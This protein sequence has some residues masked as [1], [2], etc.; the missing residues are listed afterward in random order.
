MG[1]LAG[2]TTH[3]FPTLL[4]GVAI[5]VL[6]S[7]VLRVQRSFRGYDALDPQR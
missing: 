2:L 3:W 6:I 4:G 7:V 5:I 1:R